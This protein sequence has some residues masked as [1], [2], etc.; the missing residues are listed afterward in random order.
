MPQ[1]N[2]NKS[3][4]SNYE[5]IFPVLPITQKV[6]DSD[7][8]SL[9]IHGTVVPAIALG[10][11]EH[12]WQGSH[13]PAA[14]SEIT[15]EPWYVNFT[16]DSNWYNWYMLYKWITFIDDGNTHYGRPIKDY[17]VDATMNIYDNSNNRIM[18]L[19]IINIY[20]SS[21]NEVTLS[22]RDGQENLD[23][24]VNF[25]YTRV[26]VENIYINN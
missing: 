13:Y 15:Y 7:I 17:F 12:N 23:C 25:N 4:T 16:V 24:G 6:Q 18:S 5:L 10:T 9:N 11:T 26:E 20:P 3:A 1:V 8:L 19:K 2:L 22:Q 21:L 14:I